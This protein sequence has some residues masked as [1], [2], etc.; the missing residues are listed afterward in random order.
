M[1]ENYGPIFTKRSLED[2]RRTLAARYWFRCEC[3]ACREDWPRF[4]TLTNDMVRLR[5]ELVSS[6]YS[7]AYSQSETESESERGREN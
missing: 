7:T 1:A 2:R 3:T 5:C 4:E 6:T